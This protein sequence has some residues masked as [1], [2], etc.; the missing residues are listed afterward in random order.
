MVIVMLGLSAC[1]QPVSGE[2]LKSDKP[3][4][5]EPLVNQGDLATL[6]D[7]NSEFTF[8]LYQVL[9]DTDGN[10]FY[11]PYSISLA[12]VMTY[13]GARGQTEDQMANTLNFLLPHNSLH[14]T[15]NGLDID[16]SSR[17]E[18]SKGKDEEGF[19][20]NIVNAIWGQKDYAF[21]SEFLDALAEHYGAGLRILDFIEVPEESRL[22]INN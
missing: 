4:V 7:G 2:V 5:T 18:G 19:R 20:L 15:F 3:R 6:V 12:L 21:L 8:D 16:L 1:T 14:P 10:L 11:S 9:K 17:G 22:T 13:A